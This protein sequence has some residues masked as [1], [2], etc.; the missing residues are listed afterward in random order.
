MSIPTYV[1]GYPPDGSSLGQ[2]KT[3]IRKNLDGTFLTL[4]VDHVNNNG[5]PGS[6]PPG[7]HTI[8]HQVSQTNV[9]TVSGYNQVFSGVPG[10]LIVNGTTTPAIPPGGNTQL[11]SLTGAG[12][13]SQLTGHNAAMNGYQWIGG[14]LV[15]WGRRSLTGAQGELGTVLFSTANI[16]FPNNLFNMQAVLG[17]NNGSSSDNTLS[18]VINSLNKNSFQYRYDGSGGGRFPAFYWFAIGN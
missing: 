5:Q 15:Q 16:A 8:V 3:T 18:I 17:Y 10:T 6:Q 2:T 14:L 4:A 11:Y 7:Y 9:S 12:A 13:L 1:Q